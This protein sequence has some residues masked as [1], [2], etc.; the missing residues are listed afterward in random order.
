MNAPATPPPAAAPAARQ[1]LLPI[2]EIRNRLMSE[3]VKKELV[4]VLPPQ[5]PVE[6][7]QRVAITALNKTPELV[8]CNRQSLYNS[9][10]LAAQDGLLPDGREAA[11]VPYKNHGVPTA[12]YMPMVRGLLKKIRNSGELKSIV[13]NVVHEGDPFRYWVDEGGEHLLHEPILADEKRKVTF[14]YALAKT[15]DDGVFI[16]VMSRREVEEVRAVSKAGGSGP[17]V[18]WWDEMAKKTAIRRLSKVLPMSTDLDDLIR[19]D[20]ELYD[21]EGKSE[22]DPKPKGGPGRLKTLLGGPG[23]VIEGQGREV[24]DEPDAPAAEPLITPDTSEPGPEED[25]GGAPSAQEQE[26]I[27]RREIYEAKAL[28]CTKCPP[29]TFATDVKAEMDAH[30]QTHTTAAPAKSSP[31]GGGSLF[32]K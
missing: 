19:R 3:D 6:R 25:A 16:T 30:M 32:K 26:E 29:F 20:D 9:F 11:I 17:W 24:G 28:K 18:A 21:L 23:K 14:V 7:F 22:T 31:A 15:K 10:M 1:A 12:T 27:K 13:A 5:M 4:M 8:T 2:D